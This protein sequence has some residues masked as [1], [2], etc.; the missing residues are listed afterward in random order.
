M[1]TNTTPRRWTPATLTL[2]G[3]PARIHYP[4]EGPAKVTT[5]GG[6][7]LTIDQDQARE[8]MRTGDGAFTSPAWCRPARARMAA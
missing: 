5:I 3:E 7:Y 4:V 8:I 1:T 2:D 6:R